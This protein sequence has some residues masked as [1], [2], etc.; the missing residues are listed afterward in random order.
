[1]EL[2]S[3]LSL[4]R[5]NIHSWV[6]I[7][8]GSN[9]CVMNLNNNETGNLRSVAWRTSVATECDGFCIPIKG[10]SKTTN[11]GTCCFFTEYYSDESKDLDRYWTC[12][13]LSLRTKFRRKWFIFFVIHS[14]C[15]EKKTERFISG[16]L[17]KIFRVNSHNLLIRLTIDGKHVWQQ[18]EEQKGFSSTVLMIQETLLISELFRDIQDAILLIVHCRTMLWFRADSSIVLTMLDVDS[19]FIQSSTLDWYLEVKIQARD[20]QYSFCLLI[21]LTKVTK[22]PIRSAWM[23]TVMHNTCIKH[24]RNIRT[25]KIG[26]TSILLRRKDW[27]SIK[28]DQTPSSFKIHSQSII[29]EAIRMETGEV[30][31]KKYMNHLDRLQRFPWNMI[32]R[33]LDCHRYNANPA[34]FWFQT[35][36]VYLATK[37]NKEDEAQRNQRWWQVILRLGGTGKDHGGILLMRITTK[38]Y[39]APIDL[40]NLIEEVIGT[41]IRGMIIRI[42]LLDYSWIV[43]SWRRSTVTDGRCKYYT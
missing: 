24:G 30:I 21:L 28:R 41:L 25:R 2:R 20:R 33:C 12:W 31:D 35:S 29:S 3:E 19:I 6:R 26:S 32:R 18:E 38:T 7:S 23:H 43:Y 4:N 5:D 27:S 37:K 22:I 8:H 36:I 34:Q 15:I 42:H 11:K 16:E 9:W 1:M 39:P 13:T 40:G 10:K 17:K 14:K